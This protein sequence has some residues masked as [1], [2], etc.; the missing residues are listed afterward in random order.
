MQPKEYVVYRNSK[1]KASPV[2]HKVL[3]NWSVFLRKS[4]IYW[5]QREMARTENEQVVPTYQRV[6]SLGSIDE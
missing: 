3:D 1:K 5:S 4:E 6:E 2:V